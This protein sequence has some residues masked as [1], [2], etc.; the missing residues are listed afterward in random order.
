[1][2]VCFSNNR[3]NFFDINTINVNQFEQKQFTLKTNTLKINDII[4]DINIIPYSPSFLIVFEKNNNIIKP[5]KLFNYNSLV[6]DININV[7]KN[8]T[9]IIY[10]NMY[11]NTDNNIKIK[12]INFSISQ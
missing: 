2:N 1:M 6:T 10:G 7:E 12:N 4:N 5:L 3:Q 8:K 9:Y 11:Y